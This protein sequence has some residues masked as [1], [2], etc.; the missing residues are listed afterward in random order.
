MN[1]LFIGGTG[2]IS[3]ACVE[4]A[5]ENDIQV[6]VLNR[7]E[8]NRQLPENVK[9][10]RGDIRKPEDVKYQIRDYEF[11]V[12][13]NFVAFET[14]HI[15]TDLDLFEGKTGQYIFISSASVYQTPPTMV[16][17]TESTPLKN[18]FWKYSRNKIACE[19]RLMKAWRETGFPVTIVRPS[20]TYDRTMLPFRGNYT[21]LNRLQKGKPVVVHG[22][23]T[24]LWTLT[25]H[26][27]FARGFTGLLGNPQAI[28]HSFHI[29]SDE[30]L[31]WNQIFEIV[32][33][34]SGGSYHPVYIPSSK[35]ADVDSDWGASLL[36]D[37][38]HSMIFDNT[39]IK[40][41]VPGYKAE[42]PF[43]RG[44]SEIVNWF[45][46]HPDQRKVDNVFN[47]ILEKLITEFG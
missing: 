8:S 37:K 24:S 31:S 35:I 12:V 3:S 47:E 15:E 20:H 21:V 40:K 30:V 13:V 14:S 19:V 28:G 33:D 29:T 2:V 45:T 42:V 25:H 9:V 4:T 23:G 43:A 26:R 22:D 34:A 39:K 1:V 17:V 27:D 41:L 7:G 46:K 32:S 11:D 18:P 6:T 16:P 44:A 5:L 38:S 36:G 10:I